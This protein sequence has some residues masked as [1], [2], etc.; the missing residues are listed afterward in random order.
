VQYKS[1]PFLELFE[2]RLLIQCPFTQEDIVCVSYRYEHSPETHQQEEEM[3][4]DTR[5]FYQLSQSCHF[6]QKLP[7]L[8]SDVSLS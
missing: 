8:D 7:I 2:C 1:F 3:N 5:Q 4:I 6:Y